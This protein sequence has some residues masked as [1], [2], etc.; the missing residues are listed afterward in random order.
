MVGV[1][2]IRKLDKPVKLDWYTFCDMSVDEIGNPSK[3]LLYAHI[4]L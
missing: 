1:I 2:P 4:T 3:Y